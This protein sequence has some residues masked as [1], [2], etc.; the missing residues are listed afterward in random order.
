[1]KKVVGKDLGGIAMIAALL[2]SHQNLMMY[3]WFGMWV[4]VMA[5]WKETVS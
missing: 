5:G 2:E 4:A 1:M 3:F